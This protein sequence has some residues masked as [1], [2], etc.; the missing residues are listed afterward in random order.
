[1]SGA[2]TPTIPLT[3]TLP[4]VCWP[5]VPGA[6]ASQLLTQLLFLEQ[7]QWLSP[8][9]LRE[10][11][12]G[13]IELLIEYAARHS[14][15]YEQ[16][17]REAGLLDG[18]R[19]THQRLAEL[20][21]LRRL[22]LQLGVDD[23]ACDEIPPGHG[24]VSPRAT[25]GSTGSPVT[26]LGTDLTEFFWRAITLRD[27]LWHRRQFSR[28]L[29][30]IRRTSDPRAK[31]PHGLR[32]DDWGVATRGVV[33]TGPGMLLSIDAS[34]R[35]QAEWL[36][37]VQPDYLTS[38]P[39]ALVAIAEALS[40]RGEALVR[41]EQVRTF[42]EAVDDETRRTI[43]QAF[44]VPLVDTYSAQE[45]GYLALQ[46]PEHEAYHVQSERLY[47]EVLDDHDRPCGPGEA[48]RVLVTDLHNFASPLIRYEIG[49]QAEVGEPCPCGRGLPTLRRILGRAT[50]EQSAS[51]PSRY[52]VAEGEVS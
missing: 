35:G 11:Q 3:S 50:N 12:L 29:A 4:S 47:V 32:R 39:S 9:R 52:Q 42:G 23:L 16:R 15:P 46:C 7:S 40:E 51:S 20:E 13:Q 5:P 43:E 14:A 22:D 33:D 19:L 37:A 49:D 31:T 44:G 38:H 27:H 25:S 2:T 24:K 28:L 18:G 45:V 26:V 34:A 36:L 21:P 10:Q 1:M 17:V 41:L 6:R 8:E 48:G 30:S